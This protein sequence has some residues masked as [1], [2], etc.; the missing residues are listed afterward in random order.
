MSSGSMAKTNR[1]NIA[2]FFDPR[3]LSS[4]QAGIFVLCLCVTLL[5]GY[6]SQAIG[7]AGPSIAQMLH[8]SPKALGV[9]FSASYFGAMAGALTF[10]TLADRFG[11]KKMLVASALVF[12]VFCLAI[13]QIT[14]VGELALFRFLAGVGLGG[15]VPNAVALGTEYS[16]K[17]LRASLATWMWV[18]IPGGSVLVGIIGVYVLPKYGWRSIFWIGGILPVVIAF[19]VIFILPESL[20]FLVRQ[21]KADGQIRRVIA[22]IAPGAVEKPDMEFYTTEKKLPGVPLKHLFIEGRALTTVLIWLLFYLSFL[23]L[24]FVTLWN[25]ALLRRSGATL[26]QASV[27]YTLWNAGAVL[28]TLT[29]GRIMD[30]LNY[31]RALAVIFVIAAIMV[32][33]FGIFASHTFLL[34]AC[35]SILSGIFVAGGNSG[36]IA[37]AALSYPPAIRGTGIGWAFAFGRFGAMTGPIVGGFLLGEGW[38]V[39]QVCVA[40]AATSLVAA[41]AIMLLKVHVTPLARHAG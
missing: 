33:F 24:I 28:A 32:A 18:G 16:P 36:M 7:V 39:G 15:A 19:A 10:G 31:H 37:L 9:V 17:R 14:P 23:L 29:V 41:V 38:S 13:T 2:E 8:L 3:P 40:M 26:Q 12:G 22:R 6:D 30:K 11:R 4:Y 27:S 34:V 20:A 5:D 1:I 35:L 21:A 25:P